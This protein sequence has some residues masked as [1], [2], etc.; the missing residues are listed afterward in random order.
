V[1]APAETSNAAA[2]AASFTPP[3]STSAARAQW[4]QVS[5]VAEPVSSSRLGNVVGK[6]PLLRRLRKR[7]QAFVPPSPVHKVEP[8]L[9][10]ADRR[11]LQRSSVPVDVKVYVGET[12][13]VQYAELLSEGMGRHRDLASAAVY[14]AR[15]WDFAPARLGEEKVP[16]E[17]ILHFRFGPTEVAR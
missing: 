1:T 16:G 13:K 9:N 8:T 7:P 17:V 5:V 12:G 10:A 11:A 2:P 15:R 14:A 6:I 4:P 3:P